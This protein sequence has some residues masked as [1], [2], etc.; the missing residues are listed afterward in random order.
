MARK[1]PLVWFMRS[2]RH[3]TN[4]TPEQAE[5]LTRYLNEHPAIDAIYAFKQQ[6]CALLS[7]KKQTKKQCRS[8]VPKLLQAIEE[9][10]AS[11]FTHLMTLDQT[12]HSW[13]QEIVR[14]WRFIENNGI[15]EGF[16]NKM[17]LISRQAYGFR[18]FKNYRM[19]VK[20]LCK[21]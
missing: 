18:N 16:H 4:L 11:P 21:M 10:R 19:R 12:L 17:E 7:L 8:L 3:Q 6:M 15:T 1:R 20:V 9:L 5:R 13:H 14:M 2:R